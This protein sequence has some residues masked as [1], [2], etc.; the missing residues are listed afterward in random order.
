MDTWSA[1]ALTSG[2]VIG[3]SLIVWVPW[4][5]IELHGKRQFHL[6]KTNQPHQRPHPSP[7]WQNTNYHSN[8]ASKSNG[9][10]FLCQNKVWKRRNPFF[11]SITSISSK[12]VNTSTVMVASSS[13]GTT[14]SSWN[15]NGSVCS[16]LLP[17]VTPWVPIRLHLQNQDESRPCWFD[18]P[19]YTFIKKGFRKAWVA[20]TGTKRN[21]SRATS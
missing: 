2:T 16:E 18:H 4:R 1:M 15:Q 7:W 9:L 12:E 21:L 14:L 8:S 13:F 5:T 11:T 6:M 20:N 3:G 10:L 19:D 17:S